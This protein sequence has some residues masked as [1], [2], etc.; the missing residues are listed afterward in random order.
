MDRGQ[1][2]AQLKGASKPSA[3]ASSYLPMSWSDRPRL[4]I[5]SGQFGHNLRAK[6]QEPIARSSC[7]SP[8]YASARLA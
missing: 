4:H 2:L 6:R 3:T 8:R 1:I 7:P 5:A